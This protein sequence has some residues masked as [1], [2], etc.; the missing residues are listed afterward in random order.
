M[1]HQDALRE[2][3][4]ER[5]LL[6]ELTGERR[7]VFEEHLFDCEQCAADLKA[8]VDL[9]EGARTEL[10][11]PDRLATAVRQRPPSRLNWL[12]SPAWL[13]PALAACLLVVV[14]Q[15]F[16]VIPEIRRQ[17]A[18]ANVPAVLNNLVLAGGTARGGGL[19]RVV[20]PENGS[21]LLSVDIP[22]SSIYSGYLCS[23]YSPA[24][25]LVWHVRISPQQAN[26]TVQIRVPLASTQAGENTL[27]IQGERPSEPSGVTLDDLS[28]HRFILEIQK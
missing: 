14:Y 27:L 23:L 21:F 26:D 3:S 4:V 15:T 10:A 2:M 5:Y 7:E 28:R 11:H 9:L 13:A 6:G 20:A 1:N 22:S 19:L 18:Q 8:G 12:L 16:F 25:A 17:L 24:G